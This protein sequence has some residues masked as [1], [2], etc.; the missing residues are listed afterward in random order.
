MDTIKKT[1]IT[2]C[3][4]QFSAWIASAIDFL[5]T[6]IT[7]HFIGFWYGYSTFVGALA[8]GIVNCAINYRWV[9]RPNGIKKR[10]VVTRYIIV[11]TGSI[12]LNTLGTLVL[13]ELTGFSFIIVKAIIAVIVAVVWNYQMQRLFVFK[14]RSA[15]K[16]S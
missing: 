13:T 12:M 10:R 14:N 11:W 8:G 5:V 16:S 15:S 3:K 9:F 4:A 7:A 2:F 1:F 6:I